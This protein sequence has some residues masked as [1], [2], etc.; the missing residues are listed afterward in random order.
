MIGSEPYPPAPMISRPPRHGS[1]SADRRLL[2]PLPHPAI[3]D[4]DVALAALHDRDSKGP[5]GP[6]AGH[7][8]LAC[9]RHRVLTETPTRASSQ[10]RCR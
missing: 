2:L 10:A 5:L 9:S 1:S 3:L 8:G 4:E 7:D 6:K